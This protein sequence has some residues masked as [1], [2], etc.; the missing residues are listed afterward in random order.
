MK[1]LA[2]DTSTLT[3]SV[4]LVDDGKVLAELVADVRAAHSSALLP[5]VHEVLERA[6]VLLGAVDLLAVAIG[7]GSFTGVRIAIATAK[8]LSLGTGKPLVGVPTLDA[9][10]AAAIGARG[11]VAA[12]LDARRGEVFAAAFDVTTAA[13]VTRMDAANGTPESI[14]VATR[15]AIGDR[16][17]FAIG[18]LDTE[19]WRRFSAGAGGAVTVLPSVAGS[20]LARFVAHEAVR[21]P[22]RDDDGG[23]DALYVRPSDAKATRQRD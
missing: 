13:R 23:F 22:R 4:A 21:S 19:L 18:D 10:V 7:P 9:L 5:F 20:P 17:L 1:V 11:A 2:I 15:A 14:G 16:E 6:C 8:G 12:V 3:G